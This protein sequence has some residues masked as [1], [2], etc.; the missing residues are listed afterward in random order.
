MGGSLLAGCTTPASD[1]G[2]DSAE[3]TPETW[4][5]GAFDAANSGHVPGGIVTESGDERWAFEVDSVTDIVSGPVVA[6]GTVYAGS[7]RTAYA[8]SLEDGSE[9]WSTE[10]DYKT[11]IV[12]TTISD[13][14]LLVTGLDADGGALLGLDAATGTVNWERPLDAATTPTVVDGRAF[15]GTNDPERAL[16][17]VDVDDG[18]ED[19]AVSFPDE[20]SVQAYRSAPAVRDGTVY[21]DARTGTA[22]E[23]TTILHAVSVDGAKRWSY[24]APG[25]TN[26]APAVDDESVYFVSTYN[27]EG[28]V[29]AVDRGTGDEQW[30]TPIDSAAYGSPAIDGGHLY[31]GTLGERL[32]RIAK[33]DGSVDWAKD[34]SLMYSD[35][36]V[37]DDS[38]YV[39]GENVVA[40]RKADGAERW[41]YEMPWKYHAQFTSPALVDGALLVG[42]CTKDGA[43]QRSYDNYV[44]KLG[45][46]GASAP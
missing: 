19:W 7:G 39:G 32:S 31:V 8:L 33:R 2:G 20:A 34:L 42:A 28:A 46:D 27:G 9:Q 29:Y 25:E 24:A 43:E 10:T 21:V 44:V 16:V 23:T 37:T 11:G 4:P 36:V 3:G 17:A 40:L 30:S 6:D 14:T 26:A 13:G 45:G 38:L 5:T 12:S 18:E 15:V 41:R 22:G 1:S 35:P